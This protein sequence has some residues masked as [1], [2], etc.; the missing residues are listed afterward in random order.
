MAPFDVTKRNE[1]F[2]LDILDDQSFPSSPPGELGQFEPLDRPVPAPRRKPRAFLQTYTLTTLVNDSELLR[3]LVDIGVKVEKFDAL[4]NVADWLLKLDWDKDVRPVLRFLTE[5]GVPVE[6]LG[7]F[8]TTNPWILQQ[9]ITDMEARIRY[10]ESKKFSK[11]SVARIVNKA[12]FWL[13][14]HVK[15]IDKRLGWLQTTFQLSGD[16]IRFVVSCAPKLIT[17]GTGYIQV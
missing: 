14:F 13:N 9:S 10:L 5:V 1:L 16:E 11:Q 6:E 3:N 8:V 4:Y 2:I 12:R 15:T 7:D 17:I